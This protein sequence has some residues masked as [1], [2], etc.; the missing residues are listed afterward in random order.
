MSKRNRTKLVPPKATVEDQTL[1]ALEVTDL[2]PDQKNEQTLTELDHEI[3]CPRCNNIMELSS[4]F[5]ALA[6]FCEDCTFILK[7]V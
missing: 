6:Y 2:L 4:T 1:E 7:C 5:D 3:E